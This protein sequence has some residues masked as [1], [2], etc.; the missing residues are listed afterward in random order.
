[1]T[2]V[3]K[4]EPSVGSL[5]VFGDSKANQGSGVWTGIFGIRSE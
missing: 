1:M 5:D 3:F 2:R 4:M